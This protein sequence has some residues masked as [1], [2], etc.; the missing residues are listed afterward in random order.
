M[1]S[2]PNNIQSELLTAIERY[3][4]WKILS[5]IADVEINKFK[6]HW[7][8]VYGEVYKPHRR[9]IQGFAFIAN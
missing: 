4:D 2:E 1:A 6:Q 5:N 9:A 3:K 7:S 8:S